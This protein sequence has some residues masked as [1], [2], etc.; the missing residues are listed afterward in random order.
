MNI[1]SGIKT[2]LSRAFGA[3]V[4]IFTAA[5]FA[6][7]AFAKT[8]VANA[9]SVDEKEVAAWS[10]TLDAYDAG[11]L[12]VRVPHA[13]LEK[14]PAVLARLLADDE[15]EPELRIIINKSILDKTVGKTPSKFTGDFHKIALADLTTLPV[16][17]ANPIAVFDSAHG[18]GDKVVLTELKDYETQ[19]SVIVALAIEARRGSES[20]NAVSS[21]H[22][23][24]LG[25]FYKW[26][27]D[28][29]LRYYHTKKFPQWL[30]SV[31][32]RNP[33]ASIPRGKEILTEK[34]FRKS[35]SPAKKRKTKNKT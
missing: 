31:G 10:A 17:L 19:E 13:V 2:R 23:R 16:Q 6:V 24:Q 3:W 20:V 27:E 30:R 8:D 7:S 21:I 34:D 4:A 26:L 18:N 15:R 1:T 9:F 28:G 33:Q 29:H 11:T 22:G 25:S 14:T 32:V 5:F 35:A 12:N